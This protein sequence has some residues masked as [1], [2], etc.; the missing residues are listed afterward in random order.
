MS[1]LQ[2]TRVTAVHRVKIPMDRI[3]APV[4]AATLVMDTPV[5][6]RT[7]LLPSCLF[8]LA[9]SSLYLFVCLSV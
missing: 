6:A 8:I 7:Y 5:E 9:L 4:T 1:V 3:Y 2:D